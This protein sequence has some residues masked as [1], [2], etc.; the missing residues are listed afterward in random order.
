M[1][2]LLNS[3]SS[4]E[5]WLLAG[6]REGMP[7]YDWENKKVGTVNYIQLPT[8]LDDHK[9]DDSA[10]HTGVLDR[11]QDGMREQLLQAGFIQVESGVFSPVCY[12]TPS[13]IHH[14]AENDVKLNVSRV[15]LI[16]F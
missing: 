4:R 3:S 14:V 2:H 11:A 6:I 9:L 10:I 7:V 16:G 8:G 1:I 15:M 5:F 12:I 13:Q